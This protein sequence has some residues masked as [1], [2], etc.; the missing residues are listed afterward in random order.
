MGSL[1]NMAVQI[2]SSIAHNI[3]TRKI[4]CYIAA[5]DAGQLAIKGSGLIGY[6]EAASI[7]KTL[8]KPEQQLADFAK[9][10]KIQLRKYMDGIR[11]TSSKLNGRINADTLLLRV[12]RA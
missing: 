6:N 7:S 12:T 11:T 2:K 9:S 3:R 8:R 5:A 4:G 1:S 10:N